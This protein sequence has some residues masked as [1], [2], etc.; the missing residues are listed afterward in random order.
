MENFNSFLTLLEFGTLDINKCFNYW[1]KD[2]TRGSRPKLHFDGNVF[3]FKNQLNRSFE[4]CKKEIAS[5]LL[6]LEKQFNKLKFIRDLESRI[7]LV[8]YLFSKNEN[9]EYSHGHFHEL[10]GVTGSHL[11]YK[12]CDFHEYY[13]TMHFYFDNVLA[14]LESIRS[15]INSI[16]S[17]ELNE[18]A[19]GIENEE[20]SSPINFF[21]DFIL[22]DK[23]FRVWKEFIY[24]DEDKIYYDD[25][26]IIET[27]GQKRLWYRDQETGDELF[28]LKFFEKD[29]L[30]PALA[31]E[32]NESRR[33]IETYIHNTSQE[34]QLDYLTIVLNKLNF[35]IK[36]S[37]QNESYIKYAATCNAY[38]GALVEFCEFLIK[39]RNV[40]LNT[41]IPL[42]KQDGKS[43]AEVIH[44]RKRVISFNITSHDKNRQK[45]KLI[46]DFTLE[47]KFFI[48]QDRTSIESFIAYFTSEDLSQNEIKIF[49]NCK[50]NECAYIISKMKTVFSDIDYSIIEKS[51]GII[52]KNIQE[53]HF[54]ASDISAALSK[55]NVSSS[56]LS[57]QK[58]IDAYFHNLKYK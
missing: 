11:I 52:K 31:I 6:K 49:T 23:M 55:I 21:D 16:Y 50:V 30:L 28:D 35:L 44:E 2:G 26:E 27:E 15:D 53:S 17:T 57:N 24:I 12:Q 25:V 7:I 3:E 8:Q 33:R 56:G 48:D 45:L 58:I 4:S 38:I 19:F 34:N 10:S 32:Y 29:Y 22:S 20:H 18:N 5:E 42:I 36:K 37:I 9:G 47:D 40:E 54:K 43:T 13:L 41:E 46:Y 1:Y 39:T 51:R 14:Y